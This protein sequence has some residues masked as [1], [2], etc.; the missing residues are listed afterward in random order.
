M[1]ETFA[2]GLQQQPII[3][4]HSDIIMLHM[5]TNIE[6]LR[7]YIYFYRALFVVL[8]NIHDIQYL[9]IHNI[10]YETGS[11]L[12]KGTLISRLLFFR[13]FYET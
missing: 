11:L 12:V 6:S 5:S 10:Q 13:H 4:Q 3:N 2:T 1:H 9:N 8:M 7:I